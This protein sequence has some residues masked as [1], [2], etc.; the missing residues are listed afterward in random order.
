M[1]TCRE[2]REVFSLYITL[3]QWGARKRLET[4]CTR[5]RWSRLVWKSL[6]WNFELPRGQDRRI[7]SR[8]LSYAMEWQTFPLKLF[9]SGIIHCYRKSQQRRVNLFA[10]KEIKAN[11][12]IPSQICLQEW[13]WNAGTV[14]QER[15]W[16]I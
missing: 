11:I 13:R 8:N 7:L 4:Q 6:H 14:G 9:T 15:K 16:E 2:K 12:S 1:C 3:S 5:K 10:V